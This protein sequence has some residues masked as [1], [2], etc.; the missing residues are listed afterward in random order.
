[1]KR[2]LVSV[3][4]SAFCATQISAADALFN[5]TWVLDQHSPRPGNAPNQIQTKISQKGANLTLESVFTEPKDRVLPMLYLG[6]LGTRISLT[7][8]GAEQENMVGPYYLLT[9]TTIEGNQMLT[10]WIATMFGDELRGHWRHTLTDPKHLVIE[11][12][13]IS[14]QGQR[15]AT[16]YFTRK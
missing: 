8:N 12:Q 1:M 6:I 5:G 7:A 15:G 4:F 13:E 10:D 14:K 3:V 9:K 2:A 16:L 11:I